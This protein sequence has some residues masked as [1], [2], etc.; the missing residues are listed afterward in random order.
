MGANIELSPELDELREVTKKSNITRDDSK[1]I[2]AFTSYNL[3]ESVR[4]DIRT[5]TVT[6]DGKALDVSEAENV[7]ATWCERQRQAVEWQQKISEFRTQVLKELAVFEQR[8]KLFPEDNFD[9]EVKRDANLMVQ[10]WF[11]STLPCVPKTFTQ[12]KHVYTIVTSNV[13]KV[14]S[15]WIVPNQSEDRDTCQWDNVK[16][17]K[18][19]KHYWDKDWANDH[20]KAFIKEAGITLQQVDEQTYKLMFSGKELIRYQTR[21]KVEG[22]ANTLDSIF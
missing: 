3:G 16:T 19:L 10:R 15:N 5:T 4:V 2:S 20:L 12:D 18:Q 21:I 8:T 6:E 1:R 7:L 14:N 9:D 22:S 11:L 13:S 17:Q